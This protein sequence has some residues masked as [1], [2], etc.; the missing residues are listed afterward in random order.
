M[1]FL[2]HFIDNFLSI[3]KQDNLI[4]DLSLSNSLLLDELLFIG[5]QV[6]L[7]GDLNKF[8]DIPHIFHR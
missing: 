7:E 5:D 2:V 1:I 3:M 4:H 6:E 8:D